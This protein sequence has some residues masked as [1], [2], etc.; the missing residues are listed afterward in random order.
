MTDSSTTFENVHNLLV[1][2]MRR[3][4]GKYKPAD[5]ADLNDNRISGIVALLMSQNEQFKDI[6]PRALGYLIIQK[7]LRYQVPA[8]GR[9]YAD[10]IVQT[11]YMDCRE[12][13][14]DKTRNAI[15]RSKFNRSES[16]RFL[17]T[18]ESMISKMVV[19]HAISQG[20]SIL[21]AMAL[22]VITMEDYQ[23]LI[24]Y[25]NVQLVHRLREVDRSFFNDQTTFALRVFNHLH[26]RRAHDQNTKKFDNYT[27]T[28]KT[29]STDVFV[30]LRSAID[31][32]IRDS[33]RET[34][35]HG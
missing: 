2:Y 21:P 16:D 14:S 31:F 19:N 24:R 5:Y 3:M 4:L 32:Y 29:H 35:N 28:P 22:A 30:A 27:S 18:M 26:D 1:R 10:N 33:I 34:E 23:T 20:R 17:V 11:V 7:M 8:H 13:L 15:T 25:C 6:D 9:V 12:T